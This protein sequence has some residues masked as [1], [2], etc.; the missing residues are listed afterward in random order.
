M[1]WAN[2]KPLMIT[3]LEVDFNKIKIG[4]IFQNV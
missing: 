4:E 1:V 3:S 2:D